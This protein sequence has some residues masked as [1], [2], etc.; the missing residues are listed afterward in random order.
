[1]LSKLATAGT[2]GQFRTPRHIIK[3]MDES[4]EMDPSLPLNDDS[5][6][7]QGQG[8]DTQKGEGQVRFYF[9]PGDL[10][11]NTMHV[12]SLPILNYAFLNYL[13]VQI[14]LK[15]YKTK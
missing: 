5:L 14:K 1:M 4:T 15:I 6:T 9:I 2:N 11:D 3:M 13:L 10:R 7:P 12:K 8:V